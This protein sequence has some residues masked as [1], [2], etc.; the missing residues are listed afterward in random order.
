MQAVMPAVRAM[1]R[2]FTFIF[3]SCRCYRKLTVKQR[4]VGQNW[5]LR[6]PPSTGIT[7]PVM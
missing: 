2:E 1:R 5:Y 7:A 6:N 3:V 4:F